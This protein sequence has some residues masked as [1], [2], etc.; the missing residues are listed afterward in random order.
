MFYAVLIVCIALLF[1]IQRTP[2][3]R[4]MRVAYV[5]GDVYFARIYPETWNLGTAQRCQLASRSAPTPND[6][7]DLLLCG[8][9]V[10]LAWQITWLRADVKS[11]IYDSSRQEMVYFRDSGHS[12]GRRPSWWDCTR[13]PSGLDCR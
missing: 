10:K 7:S 8:E 3:S 13:T 6:A 5:Y 4:M 9:T 11:A 12:G 2:K 1:S